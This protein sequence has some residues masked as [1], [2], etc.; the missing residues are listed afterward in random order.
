[1][2]GGSMDYLFTKVD[3]VVIDLLADQRP[4]RRAFGAHLQLVAKAL[5]DIE[6][7]DSCD[8]GRGDEDEAIRRCLDGGAELR[9][10]IRSAERVMDELVQ[11]LE[12]AKREEA[13]P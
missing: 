1:M 9:E 6:W 7:V 8:Y 5:H 2:S 3:D 13:K 12:R 11:A 4:L 10:T